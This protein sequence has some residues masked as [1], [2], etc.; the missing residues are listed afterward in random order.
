VI[1]PE[2][3]GR[4]ERGPSSE[5]LAR[6]ARAGSRTSFEELVRRHAGPLF[7]FLR[8]RCGA[9]GEAEDLV[10]ESFLVAWE[11]IASYDERWKFSTWLYTLAQRLAVSGW[12]RRR[13]TLAGSE[14]FDREGRE[15]DPCEVADVEETRRNLWNLARE[16]LSPDQY[17]ALWLRYAEEAES[18]EIARVLGCARAT[19]RV[20]LFRARRTL[21][22]QLAVTGEV[23]ETA[24]DAPSTYAW[25][26]QS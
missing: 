3:S 4:V 23:S 10:Q 25:G 22:K 24:I 18:V 19:V 15:G 13:P 11:K 2:P 5:E 14:T 21:H 9:R 12:R 20:H 6:Q 7:E 16:V 1:E 17:T 8:G 26:G